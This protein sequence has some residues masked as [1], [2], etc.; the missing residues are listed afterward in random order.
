MMKNRNGP[1]YGKV[2][3]DPPLMFSARG[4]PGFFP[5]SRDNPLKEFLVFRNQTGH[6]HQYGRGTPEKMINVQ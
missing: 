5:R 4:D 2:R 6:N 1:Y 3:G